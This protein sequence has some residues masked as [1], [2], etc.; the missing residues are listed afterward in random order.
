MEGGI[1]PKMAQGSRKLEAGFETPLS[2]FCSW[3]K[4]ETGEQERC[5]RPGHIPE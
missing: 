1:I 2:T 4:Q 3:R 5:L